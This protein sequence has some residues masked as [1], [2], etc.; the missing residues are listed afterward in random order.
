LL[1]QFRAALYH[2]PEAF[3]RE[4]IEIYYAPELSRRF[5][6][7]LGGYSEDK[8]SRKPNGLNNLSEF[9]RFG[10]YFPETFYKFTTKR[11]KISKCFRF[12]SSE[13]PKRG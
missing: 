2:R 6:R 4:I 8:I 12:L 5:R 3:A 9:R 7:F 10:G 13:P 11:K 1:P